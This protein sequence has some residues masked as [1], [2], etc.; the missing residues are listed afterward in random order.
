MPILGIIASQL[1]LGNPAWESIESYTVGSGGS[2][3][4]TFGS[5]G[6]I[7]Q[8]YKHLQIRGISRSTYAAANI[9]VGVRYNSYT[10]ANQT[11]HYLNGDGSGTA[12]AGGNGGYTYQY[13]TNTVGTSASSDVFC[14]TVIDILDYTNTSKYKTSRSLTGWDSNGSG[15]MQVI[16]TSW[17]S[18]NAI[19]QIEIS[20]AGLGSFT[21]YSSFALYGIKG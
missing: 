12:T 10:T 14:E 13:I 8:T 19:T 9:S 6:T 4:I 5:G 7:P 21:Q 20:T 18:T 2:S 1:S 3:S 15:A 11:Y 16:S 17:P